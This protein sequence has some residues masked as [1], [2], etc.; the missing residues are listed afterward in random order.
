MAGKMDGQMIQVLLPAM[1][2]LYG[3]FILYHLYGWVR[4]PGCR[5]GGKSPPRTL[6]SVIIPARN[7]R[8]HIMDCLRSVTAQSYPAA[9]FEVI[10]VN[11]HS[12]DETET[13]VR[14]F[15][16]DRVRLVNLSDHMGGTAH[17]NAY[18]KKSIEVA[19]GMARGEIILTT[20]ADCVVGKE[21]I[22]S[23][24]ECYEQ[25]VC[26]FI[27]GPVCLHQAAGFFKKL[28]SLDFI[29]LQGMT[30]A[31]LQLGHEGICN[32]ANIAYEKKAFFDVGGFSGMD[33]LASG[34]DVLLMRKIN[35]AFPGSVRFLK[36]SRAMV[37]TQPQESLHAFFQQRIRWSSKT[38][39]FDGAGMLL[40]LL[41]LYGW[42]LLFP[43]LAIAGFWNRGLWMQ[44]GLLLL[45]KT[46][47]EGLF[48]YPVSKFFGNRKILWLLPLEQFF[49]IP[50][51]LM[52]A[53]L[54]R[55]KSYQWKGRRV[56]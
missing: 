29:S 1:A 5:P 3:L 25:D 55:F 31:M 52:A 20:D 4:L 18:K 9:L 17:F 48:L 28:Q 50:Y 39:K 22:R 40:L 12:V 15:Q 54:G 34:D 37:L 24:V 51:I 36:C 46:L 21:W 47:L 19:I 43:V 23:V 42:N 56:S 35:Q 16:N 7:E 49:H 45:W 6:V 13:L 38:G 8:L 10:V 2:C 11:D 41:F 30:G 32:G 44:L 26:K 53:L 33:H 14:E 27:S